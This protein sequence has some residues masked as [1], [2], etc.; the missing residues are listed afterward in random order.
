MRARRPI[1]TQVATAP[2]QWQR[3]TVLAASARHRHRRMRPIAASGGARAE[4]AVRTTR[5]NAFSFV[6]A[7]SWTRLCSAASVSVRIYESS[8]GAPTFSNGHPRRAP[9][10]HL[11][12]Y[13]FATGNFTPRLATVFTVFLLSFLKISFF[14]GN[15][16]EKVRILIQVVW[17][18]RGR[19]CEETRNPVESY[20][21]K[22]EPVYIS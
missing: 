18:L 3:A 2:G 8:S 7:R 1:A 5:S 15:S 19:N 16:K 10:I 14:F 4:S 6:A 22:I 9:S 12:F 17:I 11:P 13:S 20:L 21:I